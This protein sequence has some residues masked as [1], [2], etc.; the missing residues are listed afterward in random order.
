MRQCD[1]CAVCCFVKSID[2]LRKP[3]FT[4]CPH[5]CP[6]GCAIYGVHPPSCKA[7]SC[8]WLKGE[9]LD[10][11]K[12][13]AAGFMLDFIGGDLRIYETRAGALIESIA[14]PRVN[15]H[16]EPMNRILG[17]KCRPRLILLYPFDGPP[18]GPCLPAIE[19]KP[20]PGVWKFGKT[21]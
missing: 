8:L 18:A 1:G 5:E 12:P 6:T 21:K 13:D 15:F 16:R 19:G 4:V 20:L 14:P 7:Y 10:C 3:T 2:E 11:D 17:V 9:L